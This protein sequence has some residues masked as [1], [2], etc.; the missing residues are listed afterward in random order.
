MARFLVALA[1]LSQFVSARDLDK[2]YEKAQ[3]KVG[4]KKFFAYVADDEQKR[5]Q[6]LMFIEKLPE[7][8]GMLFI[9]EAEQSL[10]FWMK[11][12][13]IPL[14]I[15]FFDAKGILVDQQEM[16]PAESLMSLDIPTYRS[17]KPGSFALEM[18][19][20]WFTKNGI[21]NGAKLTLISKSKSALLKSKLNH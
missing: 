19:K 18:N 4:N 12:T 3:F 14:N 8:T 15:G 10:G 17:L 7:D 16:K 13:L 21:K 5:A 11:N 9:F 1:L 2:L 20:G 6:G